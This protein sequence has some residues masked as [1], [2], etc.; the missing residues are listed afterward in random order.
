MVITP[1]SPDPPIVIVGF[2]A[3]EPIETSV[4]TPVPPTVAT[5]PNLTRTQ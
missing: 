4:S 2:V 3:E 5:V 1:V